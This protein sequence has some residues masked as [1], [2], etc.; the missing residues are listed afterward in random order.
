MNAPDVTPVRRHRS[1]HKIEFMKDSSV[2]FNNQMVK[3]ALAPAAFKVGINKRELCIGVIQ[4]HPEG[5]AIGQAKI[6]RVARHDDF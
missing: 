2:F 3:K 4:G 1:T 5:A 6:F